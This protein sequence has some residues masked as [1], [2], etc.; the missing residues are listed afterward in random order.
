MEMHN[1]IADLTGLWLESHAGNQTIRS[2][3][4]RLKF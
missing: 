1:T 2:G 3:V 4:E